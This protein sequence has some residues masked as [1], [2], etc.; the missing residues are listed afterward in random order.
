MLH[1][2]GLKLLMGKR[3]VGC[4]DTRVT[5]FNFLQPTIYLLDIYA[6]ECVWFFFVCFTVLFLPFS[7]V[8]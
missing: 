7:G 2:T 3:V 5:T 8:A 6:F 4:W 1:G